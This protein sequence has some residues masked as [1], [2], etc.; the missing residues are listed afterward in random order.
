MITW[1]AW[2]VDGKNLLSPV[3]DL[4]AC[5]YEVGEAVATC[6]RG[7]GCDAPSEHCTCGLY[8]VDNP[9]LLQRVLDGPH[10]PWPWLVF[11]VDLRGK[12]VRGGGCNDPDLWR[13]ERAAIV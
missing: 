6:T 12:I 5:F 8:A 11:E 10:S 1:R 7:R 2:R 3:S 13:A 4:P 9:G